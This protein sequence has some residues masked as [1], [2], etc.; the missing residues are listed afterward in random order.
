MQLLGVR[1]EVTE[2]PEGKAIAKRDDRDLTGAV[3]I[4]LFLAILV[5][6]SVALLALALAAPLAIAA[7]A[8]A[9]ALSA[10]TARGVKRSGWR[11]AGV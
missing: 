5:F 10:L 2:K 3:D 4:I 8:I 9:G 7:T 1:V 11:E 6:S